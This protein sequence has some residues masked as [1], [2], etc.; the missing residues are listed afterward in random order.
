[1]DSADCGLIGIVLHDK[2]TEIS[3]NTQ[4]YP[5]PVNIAQAQYPITQYQ[6]CSNPTS[7]QSV[8]IWFQS[9]YFM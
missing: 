8:T 6:Y 4:Y 7:A 2:T 1:M 9:D 3:P 5:I